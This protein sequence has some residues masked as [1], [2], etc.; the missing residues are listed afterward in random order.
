[1]TDPVSELEQQRQRA[2]KN[3]SLFREVNERIEDLS[4]SA[5]FTTFIC[6]CMD[7]SCTETVSLTIEEYEHVRSNSNWFIVLSGHE[8]TAVENVVE[9]TDR[10]LVVAKLGAGEAVARGLDPR[11][12]DRA[13]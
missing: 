13:D 2:A 4:V 10:F 8:Q 9:A 6:E 11:K 3:Q 12:R 1:M 7:Q 5:S